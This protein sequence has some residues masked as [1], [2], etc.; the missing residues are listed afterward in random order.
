MDP[1]RELE[2]LIR[3]IDEPDE[4][5]FR[6]IREKILGYSSSAIPLLQKIWDNNFNPQIQS[7]IESLMAQLRR[8]SL[9]QELSNWYTLGGMNLLLGYILVSRSEHPN[10]DEEKIRNFID[11]IKQDIW[12]E[13]NN[14]LTALEKVRIINKIIYDIY[15]FDGNRTHFHSPSNFLVD[16]LIETRKGSPISL[17]ILYIVLAQ[18]L[19]M[20]VYGVNLP[21]H[22]VLAWVDEQ[23]DGEFSNEDDEG[24]MFYINAFSKGAVFSKREVDQF[25]IQVKIAPQKAFYQPCSN[26]DIIVRLLRNL[27]FSYKK[28]GEN[29]KAA[30]LEK[31]QSI[32]IV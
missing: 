23:A 8:E 5:V 9:Y 15:R 6:K 20:P 16:Q 3:L 28:M 26:I 30:E 27:I 17:S 12:L 14:N 24:V 29:E 4:E 10:L 21:E 19:G 32:F 1:T 2:A 18:S 22:F 31:L 13:L 7:R 25:L 11:K